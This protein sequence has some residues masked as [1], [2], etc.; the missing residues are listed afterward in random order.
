MKFTDPTRVK[1]ICGSIGRCRADDQ[2]VKANIDVPALELMDVGLP[3]VVGD[4]MSVRVNSERPEPL[5]AGI[6]ATLCKSLCPLQWHAPEHEDLA[7]DVAVFKS[8]GRC[9]GSRILHGRKRVSCGIQNADPTW[10]TLW[11]RSS[12]LRAFSTCSSRPAF[13]ASTGGNRHNVSYFQEF[14]L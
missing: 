13:D 11:T 7:T 14:L 10:Q 3:G 9:V 6:I 5:G 12:H 2:A 1:R 8:G 4:G